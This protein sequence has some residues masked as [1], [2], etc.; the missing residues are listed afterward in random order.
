MS[1]GLR[2]AFLHPDLG[3]GGAERL[4]VDAATE[5]VRNGHH[6]DVFTA[7]YDPKR[8]F[9]ET[10]GS[11]GF[12]VTV[13]GGWFPRHVLGRMVAL[14]AYLRCVLAALHIVWVSWTYRSEAKG[15]VR[16]PCYDVIVVRRPHGVPMNIYR[17]ALP[18]CYPLP[19]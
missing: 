15:A 3:L 19:S 10:K 18:T 16:R 11:G 5:L 2:I 4:I 9:E 12:S 13:A 8:C 6:V 1:P 7:Y 14:C 17:R